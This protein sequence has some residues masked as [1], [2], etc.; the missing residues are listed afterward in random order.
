MRSE[1]SS[2]V[3][4]G[5][6]S[7]AS[8]PDSSLNIS[9]LTKKSSDGGGSS[10]CSSLVNYDHHVNIVNCTLNNSNTGLLNTLL[11]DSLLDVPVPV[12]AAVSKANDI[13]NS[14]IDATDMDQTAKS[15]ESPIKDPKTCIETE[16]G[17]KNPAAHKCAETEKKKLDRMSR[18]SFNIGDV[19]RESFLLA[20][21]KHN[22]ISG[23]FANRIR[24]ETEKKPRSRKEVVKLRRVI[25]DDSEENDKEKNTSSNPSEMTDNL[26]MNSKSEDSFVVSDDHVS[27]SSTSS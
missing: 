14:S 8:T 11:S 22:S 21:F 24:R 5:R 9:S 18:C 1:C 25:L 3:N 12:A 6:R 26:C 15:I 2:L 4:W 13:S 23:S 19:K 7:N 17:E 20:F 16:I 10:G 27:F